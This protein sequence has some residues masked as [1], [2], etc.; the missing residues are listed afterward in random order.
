MTEAQGRKPDFVLLFP[1]DELIKRHIGDMV[2][3]LNPNDRAGGFTSSTLS[4]LARGIFAGEYDAN[5]ARQICGERFEYLTRQDKIGIAQTIFTLANGLKDDYNKVPLSPGTTFI[6]WLHVLH[7]API[8]PMPLVLVAGAMTSLA[9]REFV[10]LSDEVFDHP[11]LF[12]LDINP[13]ERVKEAAGAL[14]IPTIKGDFLGDQGGIN[15][16]SINVIVADHLIEF[17]NSSA[18]QNS[19]EQFC[20]A[21]ARA[22]ATGGLLATTYEIPSRIMSLGLS[23]LLK[24]YLEQMLI[25]AGFTDIAINTAI[26]IRRRRIVETVMVTGNWLLLDTIPPSDLIQTDNQLIITARR[27]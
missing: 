2:H 6:S 14:G 10:A 1:S 12:V 26:L 4:A 24:L 17:L 22:L 18:G 8:N 11:K 19:L 16:G 5:V 20:R 21:A 7:N 13:T 27:K 25:E 23:K 15:P 9:V 3:A